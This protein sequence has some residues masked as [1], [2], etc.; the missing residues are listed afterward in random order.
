MSKGAVT[1]RQETYYT[2]EVDGKPLAYF[3][4]YVDSVFVGSSIN[5]DSIHT[6]SMTQHGY[7]ANWLPVVP[8][9]RRRILIR[10]NYEPLVIA[11]LKGKGVLRLIHQMMAQMDSELDGL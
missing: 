11:S 6:H 4:D 2:L 3:T 5:K 8:S 9:C 7:W 10:R 1:A